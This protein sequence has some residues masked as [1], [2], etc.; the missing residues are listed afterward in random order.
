MGAIALFSALLLPALALLIS[1]WTLKLTRDSLEITKQAVEQARLSWAQQKWFDLY[2]KA[3]QAYNALEHY[4]TAYQGCN[5][6]A[7]SAAQ[8][9]DHN[10][11]MYLIR[12]AY[13]MAV[14]FP[15]NEAIDALFANT[16]F[17][18]P[19]DALSKDRLKSLGDA[20][21]LLRQRALVNK[22]VLDVVD[23]SKGTEAAKA[24]K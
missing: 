22:S 4:Q 7:P 15:K 13:T 19:V 1:W 10:Q 11:V 14:V 3:D 21:E 17:S 6:A 16:N 5:P 24:G 8:M 23:D 12:E 18:N 2:F 20:L 9:N